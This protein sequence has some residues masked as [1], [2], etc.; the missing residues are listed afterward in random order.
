MNK[1]DDIPHP[2]YSAIKQFPDLFKYFQFLNEVGDTLYK[3]FTSIKQIDGR[4]E[5]ELLYKNVVNILSMKGLKTLRAIQCL[6]NSGYIEDASILLRSLIEILVTLKYIRK[7][8]EKYANL[9]SEYRHVSAKRK[10]KKA[11]KIWGRN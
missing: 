9:Y 7:D 11:K 2:S 4:N 1:Y 8:P 3:A 6:L 10:I 5:N